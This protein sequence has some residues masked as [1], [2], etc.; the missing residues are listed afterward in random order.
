MCDY[1]RHVGVIAPR[2]SVPKK[3]VENRTRRRR[4]RLVHE[5]QRSPSS[6]PERKVLASRVLSP[7]LP[8]A[9]PPPPRAMPLRSAP[10]NSSVRARPKTVPVDTLLPVIK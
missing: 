1:Y 4:R 3:T 5:K 7:P 2:E 10:Y 9:S 6:S 8:V